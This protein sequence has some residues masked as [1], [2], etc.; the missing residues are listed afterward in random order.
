[1]T[2]RA[3]VIGY[4]NALR[5]DDG[6]GPRAVAMLE[7]DPRLAGVTLLARHQLTPD[8]VLDIHQADFVILI[9]ATHDAPAGVITSAPIGDGR[10]GGSAW[11]HHVDPATLVA[12]AA[13]LYGQ[14]PV[15]ISVSVGIGSV[16]AGEDLSPPVTAAMP[17]LVETVAS[18][19]AARALTHA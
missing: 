12:L 3:L 6:L 2:D 10:A 17:R 9:D 5:C 15:V 18:I 16:D 1:M 14:V 8:L 11:S 13:E 4:G 7:A 19:V